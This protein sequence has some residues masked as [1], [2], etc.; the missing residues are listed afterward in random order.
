V[1]G[2]AGRT[3]RRPLR[4]AVLSG[5]LLAL[6]VR[7]VLVEPCLVPTGSMAPSLVPG[8]HLLVWKPAYGLR[9]PWF[10]RTVLE[11]PGPRRG[12]VV[13]FKDPRAGEL[14]VKRVVG[15]AGDVVELR[16]QVL[17]L[18]G[19]AQPRQDQGELVDDEP[20]ERGAPPRH[21]TCRHFRE[22]LA[23]GPVAATPPEEDAP[24]GEADWARAARGGT[25]AHDLLQCR[26]VRSGRHEGPFGPVAKGYLFV[27][28]D[29]RDRSEDGRGGW[30]VAESDVVGRVW[31][32]G[33]S[34]HPLW[35]WLAEG[36]GLRMDRLFK[37][38]E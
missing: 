31:L 18:N 32:V 26:R 34:S 15:V 29:N 23:L 21:D 13:V 10:G 19:V 6:L 14:M 28:G 35:R 8:D 20:G 4:G 37:P 7:L 2:R 33:W 38:V 1:S 11:R 12:D 30:Q 9:L 17:Y 27:L 16:E 3:G 22:W 36:P 5:L 25:M 24:S